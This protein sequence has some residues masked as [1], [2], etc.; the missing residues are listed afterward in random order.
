MSDNGP[1][2]NQ[3]NGVENN[4]SNGV[5]SAASASIGVDPVHLTLAF[6]D[7]ATRLLVMRA[8][9]HRQERGV[10][11]AIEQR[12]QVVVAGIYPAST[13]VGILNALTSALFQLQQ[14]SETPSA[15]KPV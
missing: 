13:L 5:E 2:N 10:I 12:G 4:G 11:F 3:S 6:P 1:S 7:E 15:D 9:L 14:E 8:G